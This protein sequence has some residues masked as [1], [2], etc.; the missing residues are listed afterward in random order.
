LLSRPL[1]VAAIPVGLVVGF[2]AWSLA[3]GAEAT[4]TVLGDLQRRVTSLRAP[5]TFSGGPDGYD[6]ASLA[7]EPLFVLTTGPGAVPQPTVRLD[8]VVSSKARVAALLSINDRPAEWLG[9][10]ETR[11]GVTLQHVA[12]GKVTIDTVYGP[13]EVA[14]GERIGGPPPQAVAQPAVSSVPDQLPPGLR[15]LPPPASAPRMP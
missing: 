13:A 15:G 3:G 11:D 4:D 12:G 1:L 7:A 2:L 9:L 8:G 10:G 14:L 6:V 5:R